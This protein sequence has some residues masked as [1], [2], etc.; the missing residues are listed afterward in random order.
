[1]LHIL[2]DFAEQSG[3]RNQ[4]FGKQDKFDVVSIFPH[5]YEFID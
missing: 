5:F 4:L 1:M 2:F 3:K